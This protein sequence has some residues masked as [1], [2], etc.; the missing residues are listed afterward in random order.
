MMGARSLVGGAI[1]CAIAGLGGVARPTR[2]QWRGALLVGALFFVGCH[3][4]MAYAQRSVPSGLA[5]LVMATLPLWVP[6]LAWLR[7]DRPSARTLTALVVGFAGVALLIAVSRGLAPGDLTTDGLALL[8]VIALLGAALS[9]ALGSVLSRT[10]ALPASLTQA[11]GMELL[12]GGALLVVLG[13]AGGEASGVDVPAISLRSLL[14]LA[15]LTLGGSV[16]AF[17]I[18]GWLLR[19]VS[20]ERVATYAY[21]NPIVAVALGAALLGETVTPGMLA[22]SAIILAA[23]VVT[24]TDRPLG[25]AEAWRRLG[26]THAWKFAARR[27]S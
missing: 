8:P 9:W 23:V 18:Y 17:T 1:L 19:V 5:A 26:R 2:A 3:G 4:V 21:V 10:V 14:G 7:G 20:P 27:L 22:A 13:L 11:A 16:V 12:L 24:L 6:L 25:V 15:W